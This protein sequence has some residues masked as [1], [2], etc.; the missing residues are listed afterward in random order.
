M[1]T[2]VILIALLFLF[3][4]YG[5]RSGFIIMVSQLAAAV[6]A[7]VTANFC[8]QLAVTWLA[9]ALPG[10]EGAI[11]FTAFLLVFFAV[12]RL[13]GFLLRLVAKV[14]NLVAKL[15]LISCTNSLLGAVLGF[16]E[17]GVLLG[18]AIHL[19]LTFRIEPHLV[20]WLSTSSTAHAIQKVFY[21]LLGFLL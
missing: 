2:E 18:S 15:P 20:F 4:G 14:L 17:G 5:Y 9:T 12:E 21:P 6:L 7:F 13:I 19:I 3:A 16:L 8:S 10:H 1:Y 11:R